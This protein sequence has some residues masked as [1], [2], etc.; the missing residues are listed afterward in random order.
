MIKVWADVGGTFTDC[1]VA[2][3]GEALRWTK[4]LSNGC[5][6][7]SATLAPG[8][9]SVIDEALV[10]QADH[11]WNGFSFRVFN[12]DGTLRCE[13]T[14]V[15]FNGSRGELTLAEPFP[16][17][18]AN[19]LRYELSSHWTAPVVATRL[20]LNLPFDR[21][22]P[23]VDVRLGTTRGTNALLTRRGAATCFVTT[24]GF[25]DLLQIGYQDRPD[26][27]ALSI[28][29]PVPLY[30]TAIE[31][32]ERVDSRGEVLTPLDEGRAIE[33][34]ERVYRSGLQ[35]IA[36]GLLNAY[37]NP[38]HELQLADI[39]RRVGFDSVSVSHEVA[40]LIKVVD[41]CQT[42]VLDAYLNPVI[43][44]YVATIR[45][46]FGERNSCELRLMTSGGTLL[47]AGQ[48]RGKDSILSGPAGGVVALAEIA[49]R[50]GVAEA[51]GLDMGGTSTD[52]S[53]FDG[54]PVRQYEAIKAG[55]R[56]LTPMMAIETVAAG[57]GSVCQFDDGRMKVG[58]QSAGADPGPACYGRGGPLTVTDLN[59]VLGRVAASRF[60]F[61]VDRLAAER[62]LNAI[63]EQMV[64]AGYEKASIETL[65]EGFRSIANHHMAEAVRT[66]STAQGRDPRSMSLVG[67]GGAAGQHL[68]DVAMILGIRHIIDHPQASLLSAL[69]MGL[70]STGNTQTQGVYRLLSDWTDEEIEVAIKEVCSRSI[71]Q[72]AGTADRAHVD[73]RVTVDVRYA[74]TE[75][76]IELEWRD[77]E[78]VKQDFYTQHRLH[79]GY[80]RPHRELEVVAVR[81]TSTLPGDTH[82]PKIENVMPCVVRNDAFASNEANHLISD[83]ATFKPKEP[84]ATEFQRV[85][86][87]GGWCDV[88]AFDRRTLR[89]GDTLHG[90]AV[91]TAQHHTLIIEQGWGGSVASDGCIVLT[92]STESPQRV[93]GIDGRDETF[94]DDR[95]NTRGDDPTEAA[96]Y[97][98]VLLEIFARRFQQ[99]AH[100]MGAVLQRTAIS[101]NVKERRDF[102]CAIFRDDGS[103]VANA[104][105]VPVHLGAMGHTVRSLMRQFPQMY[106]GDC[107]V[108]N[109]PFAGGSH[110][111]DVTVVCPVFQSGRKGP[112]FFVASRAHHAEIGGITPGSM[113]PDATSLAEEGVL[114]RGFALVRNGVHHEGE[115]R[116]LLT[117]AVYPSRCVEENLADI[118]AQQAAGARGVRDLLELVDIYGLQVVD[119]Y[120]RYLQDVA[121]DAVS[122]RLR[123]LPKQAM[124]F[125]DYLDDGTMIRVGMQVNEGRLTI[126]FAGTANVHPRGFNATPAIVTAAVL[127]VLR[128]LV[129]RPLP[130]NEGVLRCIDLRIPEGLLNPP[131]H[132]DPA[133]CAAVVAGNVETSQRVVDVLLGAFGVVAASQGT[134]NNFLVGDE[135]FGYYETICGGSGATYE[136]DGASAVHTHMTNTRITDPE[137]LELR[138]PLRLIRFAIRGN[139]G[140]A[141]ARR[142]G[143]GVVREFEFLKPLTVSLLTSRRS[144][145]PPYGLGIGESG[146]RGENWLK[147][148]Q[149]ESQLLPH[150]CRIEVDAGDRLI[151]KTPGGGG[152]TVVPSKANNGAHETSIT[153]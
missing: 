94:G 102:S 24:K 104:P 70:A 138:Y 21:P 67:F 45:K 14:V 143:D 61:P 148:S 51:I 5:I 106:P 69:G 16:S 64:Q 120:M 1:F 126:D 9:T 89:P 52:V 34:F 135:T 145:H 98:P 105:H 26:L 140:G 77:R 30:Q 153:K 95:A 101:V 31:V 66:V 10:G 131:R 79:F 117:D 25:G 87:A 110:L 41:R 139:S 150:A 133:R 20:L 136:Q 38:I 53:R 81:V 128:T 27:F 86:T 84:Q 29:K 149:Q 144:E 93:V 36:I 80:V 124:D 11:F 62:R 129:D 125:E 65:A 22:M 58:P 3:P 42:T 59:V 152:A 6:K 76:A 109:D 2:V 68:C 142:G 90:P 115:L 112:V 50:H 146:E 108:S 82:L 75:T 47:E 39:A 18:A 118:A 73:S 91:V 107:Y 88:P 44:D 119:Q 127:Y 57:G 103:L 35:S 60:P 55:T 37:V 28:V 33:Q 32:S 97:D 141:G 147:R 99:I 122:Q 17:D 7:G 116:R 23:P 63:V 85:W 19:R 15:D 130:L 132:D 121:A 100:Q 74:G 96:A 114:I 78:N 54:Q 134:M 8:G 12:D 72:I 13:R 40:P 4:V 113:P 46:Q 123:E 48:F 56:I 151:I 137:V 43:S 92:R 111:P 71:R 83:H 49:K